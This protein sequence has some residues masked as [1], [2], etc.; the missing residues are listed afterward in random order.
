MVK[1]DYKRD[2]YADLDLPNTADPEVIKKRFREL[3]M[4]R[5][6]HSCQQSR[7]LTISSQAIPSG[8]KSG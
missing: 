7:K 2:Y 1:A 5:H 4:K 6:A 8:Q 3:G